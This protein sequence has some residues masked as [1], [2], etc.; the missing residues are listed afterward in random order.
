LSSQ[1]MML[2]LSP[3]HSHSPFHVL[4]DTAACSLVVTGHDATRFTKT[5]PLAFSCTWRYC[6]ASI[7]RQR[8]W[9][10]WGCGRG[11]SCRQ[12]LA[13]GHPMIAGPPEAWT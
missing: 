9:E 1:A 10:A 3:K 2:H 11:G 7:C 12:A 5:Q 4:G 8:P 6:H 13:G